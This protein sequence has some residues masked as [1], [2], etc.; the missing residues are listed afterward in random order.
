MCT[1]TFLPTGGEGFMLTSN[2][3]T[4]ASRPRANAPCRFQVHQQAVFFPR[5]PVGGGTWIAT[6][7]NGWTLCLLNG[8]FAKHES[9]PP[10]RRSRGLVLL[11]FYGCRCPE[12][13]AKTYDFC[14]IEPFT[15]LIVQA[16]PVL[17]L[18][19]IRWDGQQCH[20]TGKNVRETHIWSS[21]TLYAPSVVQQRQQWYAAWLAD[22]ETYSLEDVFDFHRQ[23]GKE[24][25]HNGL[26][27]NRDDK[28]LTVSITA[29]AHHEKEGHVM[30]YEDLLRQTRQTYRLL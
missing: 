26:R 17:T 19:E 16:K 29:V 25:V 9:Q 10:Y 23:A 2:R 20:L 27:M 14:G 8:A 15:L 24:D 7:G 1:V 3:D 11:D 22:R 30:V 13:F 18:S 5:D 4:Q 21:A 12:T 28:W 6:S